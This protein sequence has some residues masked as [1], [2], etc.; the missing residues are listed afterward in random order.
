MLGNSSTMASLDSTPSDNFYND[1]GDLLLCILS[2]L[3]LVLI[4]ILQARVSRPG[5]LGLFMIAPLSH[6]PCVHLLD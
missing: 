4:V 1:D 6:M 5:S 2:R 3:F